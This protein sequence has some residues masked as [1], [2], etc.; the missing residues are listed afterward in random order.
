MFHLANVILWLYA[1]FPTP[2]ISWA[3]ILTLFMLML[4]LP[5]ISIKAGFYLFS[6]SRMTSVM[7][8]ILAVIKLLCSAFEFLCNSWFN[9]TF[10]WFWKSSCPGCTT[11]KAETCSLCVC[12]CFDFCTANSVYSYWTFD[13]ELHNSWGL[14][15]VIDKLLHCW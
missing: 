6:V 11:D 9:P 7:K 3:E 12:V 10:H 2:L 15:L 8:Y 4:R 5:V 13:K 1:S 14:G